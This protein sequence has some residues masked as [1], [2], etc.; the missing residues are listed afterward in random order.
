MYFIVASLLMA[1]CTGYRTAAVVTRLGTSM[2]PYNVPPEQVTVLFG[3]TSMA[4]TEYV[5]L[6]IVEAEG[7]EFAST[8]ELLTELRKAASRLG[9]NMVI[10][11]TMGEKDAI[12]GN[13]ISDVIA[14]TDGDPKTEST[15][16]KYRA[17]VM[18]GVAIYKR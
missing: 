5:Q 6:A 3:P 4:D 9:A 8:S 2:G 10:N 15:S 17:Q 13:L 14:L 18:R 16:T 1:G 11:T 12:K 7:R